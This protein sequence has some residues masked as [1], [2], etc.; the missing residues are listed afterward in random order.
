MERVVR[1]LSRLPTIGRKSA[2]RL[3]FHLL[4]QPAD[5]AQALGAALG[6]LHREVRFCSRCR[7]LAEGDLCP[8]CA[9]PSR[10][11]GVVCVVEDFQDVAALEKSRSYAGVYHVLM[12]RLSPLQ[13]VTPD[14]LTIDALMARLRG[15]DP[16]VREVVLATNPNVD[17]DA[18]ALYLSGL[19]APLGV[20][21]TRLGLGL[22]VGSSLEYSDELTLRKAFEGRREV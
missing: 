6:A 22:A 10:D 17:G 3:A 8:V 19:I 5:Q 7:F 18:T 20:K 12:G 13:G 14:D 21:V 11:A 9:D 16:P 2:Q 4:R 1:E 15:G